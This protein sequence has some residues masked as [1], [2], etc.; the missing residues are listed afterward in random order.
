MFARLCF[1]MIAAMLCC[2]L[3]Y[4][5]VYREPQERA[6]QNLLKRLYRRA[7]DESSIVAMRKKLGLGIDSLPQVRFDSD[8]GGREE[9]VGEEDDDDEQQRRLRALQNECL[10]VGAYLGETDDYVD[11]RSYCGVTDGVDYR[12]YDK[13]SLLLSGRLGRA[14]GYCVPNDAAACNVNTSLLLYTRSPSDGGNGWKCIPQTRA[15][16][17]EGGNLILVCN[18]TLLDRATGRLWRGHI[19]PTLSFGSIDEMLPDGGG[20]RFVCPSGIVDEIGNS[21]ISAPFDRLLQL[22]NVCANL[23]PYADTEI[24]PNF[25][26]GRCLCGEL[27]VYDE[28]LRTC[29]PNGTQFRLD[30]LEKSVRAACNDSDVTVEPCVESWTTLSKINNNRSL[31]PCGIAASN[32]D[33]NDEGSTDTGTYPACVRRYAI[34]FD[35]PVPSSYAMIS[36]SES[37]SSS[38]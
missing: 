21:Y 31:M 3:A 30:S 27:A 14:G 37:L 33:D 1:A 24:T 18:G 13:K 4:L 23:I 20:Y 19:D 11:C 29:V 7:N 36:G 22:H 5:A 2:V 26:D 32:D 35:R 8:D 12:F 28:D 15:F 9:I 34:V 16:G 17:G 10:S 6:I 38:S 25:I